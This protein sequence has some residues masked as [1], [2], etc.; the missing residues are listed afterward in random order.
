MLSA[1]AP[2]SFSLS[3]SFPNRPYAPVNTSN[4][5]ILADDRSDLRKI[6]PFDVMQDHMAV[7]PHLGGVAVAVIF[8]GTDNDPA[9]GLPVLGV[10]YDKRFL[11]EPG[12]QFQYR[13]AETP[14]IFFYDYSVASVSLVFTSC[15]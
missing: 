9:V 5:D 10:R 12:S 14:V 4:L 6:A 1:P 15:A 7:V 3:V 13:G 8:R 2:I 11:S